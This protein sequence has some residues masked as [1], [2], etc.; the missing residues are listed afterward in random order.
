MSATEI[1]FIGGVFAKENENEVIHQ[2]KKGVEFSANELQLRL[3]SA[4]RELAPTEVV[5]APFIGHYPN[6]SS[7]PI[8]RGF[9]EPQ[10]LCRYVRFNNLWGFRNLSRTR[11]LRRTVRD[12]V[13]KPG[14][15]KLIVAFSAHDP[16]LSAAAY[17][18]RLDPSVRVCA[19]LPDLPQYMNLELHPGVLYTLFKQLD[20][21]LI[22]RHLRSADA[23]VVLTEPMAA[24]L[25]VADRPYA[26]V[27]GVV[28]RLPEPKEVQQEPQQADRVIRIV[29]TG[30]MNLRFGIGYL[31]DA[32]ASLK[33]SQY[34][35]I[36]CGDG[37]A[38]DRIRLCAERDWRITFTGQI[39]PEA[40]ATY[41]ESATV[42]VNPRPNGEAYTRYSFPSKNIDYLLS[43]KPVVAF[44][45]DGMSPDYRNFLFEARPDCDPAEAL[46]AAI[47]AAIQASP[48]EV[49]RRW[50]AFLRYASD[51]LLAR[52]VAETILRISFDGEE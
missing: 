25:Y 47:E 28:E 51:R 9:S 39:T 45:L 8:F 14:D 5:S 48:E 46:R 10:S 31:L 43:G 17:A 24:M 18:K 50:Q 2:A 34:R 23:S 29:Y 22:Y 40:A 4:L 37:D 20:V 52:T 27:E 19:F 41:V 21:R 32:F 49:T 33:G 1:L 44:V 15:R 26:V 42:L 3:I 36:L 6:R 7:S 11:S 38:A 35:L 16:F 12:F 13:R 30:K